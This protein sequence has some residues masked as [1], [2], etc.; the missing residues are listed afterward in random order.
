MRAATRY[1]TMI[2]L[3]TARQS[4]TPT[5]SS[6]HK[7]LFSYR[8]PAKAGLCTAI[9]GCLPTKSGSSRRLLLSGGLL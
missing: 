7:L 6:L 4:S 9:F 1:L 3:R 2:C 8:K 5:S